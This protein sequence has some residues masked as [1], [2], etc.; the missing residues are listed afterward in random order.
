MSSLDT[1]EQI[2]SREYRESK[3]AIDLKDSGI[4]LNDLRNERPVNFEV[5]P[6]SMQQDGDQNDY[7]DKEELFKQLNYECVNS[8]EDEEN[9]TPFG[10]MAKNMEDISPSKDGSALKV[11]LR[12]GAG[13]VVPPAA[14]CRVHYN[15]YVEYIDEPF[16]SSYIRNRQKQFKLGSG[17]VLAGWEIGVPTMKRGETARFMFSP[18]LGFGK[19][20]CPPRIPPNAW[21]LFEI[22]LISFVDQEAADSF[23]NFSEEERKQMPFSDLLKV[24]ESLRLTGNEAFGMNQMGRARGQYSQAAR[25]LENGHLQNEKEEVKMKEILLK[26][27]LNIS[28]CQLKLNMHPMACK[29]ARKAL[30]IQPK[31][32]KALWRLARALRHMGE[33]SEAKRK[34][35]QASQLDPRNKDIMEELNTL[36]AEMEKHKQRESG[37]A[38]RMFNMDMKTDNKSKDTAKPKTPG[39]TQMVEML[40][41][42]LK[43][44]ESDPEQKHEIPLPGNLTPAEISCVKDCAKELGLYMYGKDGAYKISKKWNFGRICCDDQGYVSP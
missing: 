20:G 41:N 4:D 33:Y 2:E 28:L 1:P 6:D 18:D 14:L 15:A 24:V 30:E 9:T 38:K 25:L 22:Q 13:A 32:V 11:I 7:F 34:I 16:D 40:T 44:Y 10:R 42:M 43:K 21:T 36:N 27:Y 8:G 12:H 39:T 17:E 23:H 31:N 26:L 19:L 29:Y 5:D 3:V 35:Y 37:M